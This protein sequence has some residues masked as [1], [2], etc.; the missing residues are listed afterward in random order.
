MLLDDY[1]WDAHIYQKLAFDEFA[2]NKSVNILSLPTGQGVL[3][4]PHSPN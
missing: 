2:K 1:G 3:M 4:K